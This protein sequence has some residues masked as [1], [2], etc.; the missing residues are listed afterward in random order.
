M[1]RVAHRAGNPRASTLCHCRWGTVARI[2]RRGARAAAVCRT[3]VARSRHSSPPRWAGPDSRWLDLCA[4]PG[5]GSAAGPIQPRAGPFAGWSC[6][7]R[8]RLVEKA[9]AGSAGTHQVVVADGRNGPWSLGE[10]RSGAGRYACSAS[11]CCRRRPESRLAQPEDVGY[12]AAAR[13]AACRCHRGRTSRRNR[14][15]ARP[16]RHIAETDLVADDVWRDRNDL[17]EESA[18]ALLPDIPDTGP[19]PRLRLWPHRRD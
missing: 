8:G 12:E 14:R 13:A 6:G 4:G 19:G 11:G 9:L 18:V 10:F 16:V 5:E 1:S 2:D 15:L 7:R 17:T 3:R